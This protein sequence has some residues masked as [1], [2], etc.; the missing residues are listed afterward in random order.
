VPDAENGKQLRAEELQE[1]IREIRERVRARHP[2]AAAGDTQLPLPDLLPLVHARDAAESKVAAIGTVNPRP[3]GLVNNIAQ[4]LKRWVSR[5]LD[6]HV[7]EQVEFNR[8]AVE[9]VNTTIEA[10]NESNRAL[11]ELAGLRERV[12]ETLDIRDHWHEWRRGWEEKLATNEAQFLRGLADLRAAYEHRATQME[13]NLRD[14]MRAQHRDFEGALERSGL[15]IQKNL[16]ADLERIRDEYERL[17]HN[18]LRVLRQR[19][20]AARQVEA[21]AAGGVLAPTGSLRLDYLRFSDRFRGSEEYVARNQKFYLEKFDSCENVLDIGCGRGEFLVALRDAGRRGRG[22]ELS[23]ELV[24]VCRQKGLDVERADMFEYLDSLDDAS[25]DGVFCSQVVEHLPPERLPDFARLLGKKTRRGGL[26]AI[27]TPNPECLAIFAT[28]FYLD[29]T[30]TRPVPA[31][32]LAFYLE[33]AGFGRIEVQP[34]SP[35]V[36][37][38]PELQDLPADFRDKFF[39][40]LDYAIIGKRL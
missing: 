2:S 31:P 23:E 6:W 34:L 36:E 25:L 8:A 33:E 20:S 1:I 5:A 13:M 4:A 29:P 19:A 35:A 17:I 37:S 32:L 15:E 21:P 11:S 14:L 40:G 26:A 7:R 27:E 24:N 39:G 30:H 18:E 9:C 16:W 22:L 3:P 12:T 10:L 38:M 28:H